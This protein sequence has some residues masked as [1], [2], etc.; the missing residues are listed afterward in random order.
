MEYE[1]L[2]PED[3]QAIMKGRLRQLEQEHLGHSLNAAEWEAT[4]QDLESPEDRKAVQQ[5]ID[6]GTR[7]IKAIERKHAL[8]KKTLLEVVQESGK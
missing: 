1:H 3:R 6:Q 8:T 7:A 4:M 2:T 5:Q